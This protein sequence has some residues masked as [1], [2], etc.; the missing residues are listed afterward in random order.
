[1]INTT[2]VSVDEAYAQQ[3]PDS[4]PGHFVCLTV[5]DT[6]S[7]MDRKT[8][9]RIF[10]PFFSTKEV[11]K[12]TGLG[13][14]TVYGIVKQHEGWIEVSS[15]VGVGTTFKI[16]FPAVQRTTESSSDAPASPEPVRGGRE[17]IL[18]VEDEP[19]LR[20][21]IREVLQQY[22]YQVIE[23]GSGIEALR[24]W[25]EFD[26][27]VDLL[28]T[29]MVMPEGMNG[30]ELA[31]QLKRRKPELRVIFSSGYSPEAT[32]K[33]CGHSDTIFLSKPYMPPQ[34]ART[35]RQCLDSPRKRPRELM[36]M[37]SP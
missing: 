26:G 28:L 25:D 21:L 30:R 13:L 6:G 2:T 18:V 35:V 33:D 1:Y 11:G 5:R 8:L 20:E 29:D 14:A 17:T 16:Y 22:Q 3:H 32:G 36:P 9:D 31:A 19:V 27:Q 24:V 15:E 4:R 34:L 7:G 12:G 10:E 37:Q 23:A